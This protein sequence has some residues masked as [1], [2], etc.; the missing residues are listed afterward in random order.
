MR[1]EVKSRLFVSNL[2]GGLPT[3][4]SYQLRYWMHDHASDGSLE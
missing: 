2:H 3:L 1:G 4:D